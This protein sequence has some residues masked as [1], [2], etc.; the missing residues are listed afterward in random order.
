MYSLKNFLVCILCLY[1]QNINRYMLQKQHLPCI[2]S[3]HFFCRHAHV[4]LVSKS[5]YLFRCQYI[6]SKIYICT[7]KDAYINT[8][9]FFYADTW[10]TKDGHDILHAFFMHACKYT[11]VY[12]YLQTH[13]HTCSFFNQNDMLKLVFKFLNS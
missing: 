6:D 12:L 7:G 3:T 8:F 5:M 2:R 1:K 9:Y 13:A 4:L 10:I 11:S